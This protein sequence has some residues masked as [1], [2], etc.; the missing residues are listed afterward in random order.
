RP[1]PVT[2]ATRPERNSDVID[3]PLENGLEWTSVSEGEGIPKPPSTANTFE[4]AAYLN[5]RRILV[6][7][8]E[9]D[10]PQTRDEL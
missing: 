8:R 7:G 9:D 1:P 4:C 5:Y 10:P 3:A 2:M 6:E